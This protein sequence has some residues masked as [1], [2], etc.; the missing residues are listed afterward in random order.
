MKKDIILLIRRELKQQVDDKTKRTFQSFFKET[1]TA[2]GVKTAMVTKIAKQY[3]KNVKS[4]GKVVI[5]SLCEEL[6]TSDYN[7]EAFIAFKWVQ[8]LYHEYEPD[9]FI[10]FER[11]LKKYVNNWAKCDT[12]CNHPIGT[13]IEQYP[14]YLNNLKRWTTSENRWL[15][16]A[17]AVSLVIPAKQGK[18]LEDIFEIADS[19]LLDEDDLVRKGYGWMLKEASIA[20]Q[21]KVLN[22]VLQHKN[23][24]PRTAL[25]YAIERMPKELRYLAMG[26]SKGDRSS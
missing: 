21:E 3:F 18:F 26:K 5:F 9:D 14:Q 24:M 11:W 13:F 16:R 20:H 25:R 17:S 19:L 8:W 2:Y 23:I 22:Y 15:R 7:E 12:L 4:L 1:V 6:L 10:M